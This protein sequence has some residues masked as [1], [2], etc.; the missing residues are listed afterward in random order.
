MCFLPLLFCFLISTTHLLPSTPSCTIAATKS[1]QKSR[2]RCITARRPSSCLRYSRA[3]CSACRGSSCTS[4]SRWTPL[5]KSVRRITSAQVCVLVFV[6][7]WVHVNVSQVRGT[8]RQEK[9]CPFCTSTLR[10]CTPMASL[11]IVQKT[12]SGSRSK[13]PQSIFDSLRHQL[14]RDSMFVQQ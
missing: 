9:K 5:P 12:T 14:P 8:L 4:R 1:A 2:L 10:K 7:V 3:A 13:S 11:F 6:A